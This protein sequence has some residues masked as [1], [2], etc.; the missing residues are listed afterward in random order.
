MAQKLIK[1]A[2]SNS[3][4]YTQVVNIGG[5]KE[6]QLLIAIRN[7]WYGSQ[8]TKLVGSLSGVEAVGLYINKPIVVVKSKLSAS[9]KQIN[10][11]NAVVVSPSY[12]ASVF[13]AA[14]PAVQKQSTVYDLTAE[15][16]RTGDRFSRILPRLSPIQTRVDKTYEVLN[17]GG[18]GKVDL[19]YPFISSSLQVTGTAP[20]ATFPSLG[21]LQYALPAV[22]TI[23]DVSFVSD[24]V[25][26]VI[27]VL[28]THSQPLGS[29]TGDV[30]AEFAYVMH[31]ALA[32]LLGISLPVI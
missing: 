5:T 4:T 21:Y 17:V 31:P 6:D 13:A 16:L 19:G 15:F 9:R 27:K 20:T 30:H 10:V 28:R 32:N 24:S 2:G 29:H 25:Y 12:W 18:V 8:T 14:S 22:G 11:A 23:I 1:T 3:F 26:N 7:L